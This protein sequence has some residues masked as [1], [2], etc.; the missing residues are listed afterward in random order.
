[1][2]AIEDLAQVCSI[3]RRAAPACHIHVDATQYLA[4]YDFDF[5]A[6]GCDSMAL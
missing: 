6:S 3:V 5:G 1:M 2:G 4:K